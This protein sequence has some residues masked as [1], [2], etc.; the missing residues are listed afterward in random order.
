LHG[1]IK[2][3]IKSRRFYPV[4]QPLYDTKSHTY[5][6]AEV[7]LRWQGNNEIIMPELF[8]KEAEGTGLIVPITIQII[9][10]AFQETKAIL[11]STP[12]F[13]L[14]FNICALHF[15]ELNFF[16][17]F[18]KLVDQ[19]SISPHQILF[20]ITERDL[21]D[22]HNKQ[23]INKMHE[24]RE[25]GYSL[26]VDDYGTGYSSISYLQYF[27]FNYLKI[28]KLFIHAIGT[29]AITETLND[30]II[31]LAKKINVTIIAEGVETK[32]QV[33]YLVLHEVQFLQGWYFSKELSIEQLI[34]LLKEKK[35][36]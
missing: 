1:A 18:Y 22:E 27:P 23:Y 20:E 25:A 32:E 10:T 14:S 36:E 28:D 19:Y 33:N 12:T 11:D 15:T 17:Q 16:T 7:L 35:N 6:G 5:S 34:D 31:N 2:K 26:A 24:L 8:I 21:L 13:H 4:Y 3:A 29:K 30:V 9:E